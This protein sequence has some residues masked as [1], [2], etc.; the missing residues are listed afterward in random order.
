MPTSSSSSIVPVASLTASRSE[1]DRSDGSPRRSGSS[2][3]SPDG[4]RRADGPSVAAA[5]PD[6]V[7][8]EGWLRVLERP[9]LAAD[10][11]IDRALPAELNP[12]AQ[13]GAIANT[14]FIVAAASGIVL[15]F[16]YV[17]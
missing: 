2:S 15:L 11:A 13:T 12:L 16:W 1:R 6:A 7:R 14:A 17:P 5:H 3:P 9:F 4:P 8:G 10:R